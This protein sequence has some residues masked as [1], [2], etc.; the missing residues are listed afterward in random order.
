MLELRTTGTFGHSFR[1]AG[2]PREQRSPPGA[3]SSAVPSPRHG[4]IPGARP[5]SIHAPSLTI[6]PSKAA[7]CS[8]LSELEGK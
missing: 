4:W 5:S 1:A 6:N 8:T 2:A 3:E 7:S